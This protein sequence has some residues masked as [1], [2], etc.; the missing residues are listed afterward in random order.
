MILTCQWFIRLSEKIS[1]LSIGAIAIFPFIIVPS[2]DHLDASLINHERIHLRQQLELLILP[3]YIW[4]VIAFF[5]K[6]YRKVSFE[7][8]AF[9]HE[10]DLDYLSQRKAYSFRHYL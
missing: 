6:G 10:K 9:A 3:F 2:R 5:R 1:G 7:Q 4:Y 8:E